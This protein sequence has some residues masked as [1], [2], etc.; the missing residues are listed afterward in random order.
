MATVS[1]NIG[2]QARGLETEGYLIV[3]EGEFGLSGGLGSG[4]MDLVVGGG[5]ETYK[6]DKVSH[7]D[8]YNVQFNIRVPW[9]ATGYVEGS[10]RSQEGTEEPK[11]TDINQTRVRTRRSTV[12]L[13]A[14]RDVTPTF[15]WST[16]VN[17]ITESRFDRELTESRVDLN[18][19]RALS[20]ST[21]LAFEGSF[22]QG[23]EDI[24]GDSWTGSY[25]TL[26]KTKRI[27]SLSLLGFRIE[28]ENLRL[29]KD[30]GTKELSDVVSF[31]ARYVEETR[32]GWTY[33]SELGMDGIR[34]IVDERLWEPRAEISLSSRRERR[35]QFNSSLSTSSSLQ[36][37]VDQLEQEIAWTRESQFR[38]GLKWSLNRTFVIEPLVRYFRAEL[39]SN[40]AADAVN[41][42]LAFQVG[43]RWSIS[44]IWSLD[45]AAVSEIVEG[46][47]PANDLAE[48]SLRLT[49]SG[50]F[51]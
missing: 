40:T 45:T 24:A 38:A 7:A 23:T 11:L 34:P 5:L 20:R 25:F 4:T 49:L 17:T 31:V 47:D 22:N 28:W 39:F 30:D 36:D 35:V 41:R 3:I 9:T 27:G 14:G 13:A 8:N 18:W 51:F 15:K 42:T 21:S 37:P 19:D 32:S 2:R 1:D 29:K 43:T 12:G 16:G 46:S 26:D 44:R 6:S 10:G 33:T 50:Q 48:K